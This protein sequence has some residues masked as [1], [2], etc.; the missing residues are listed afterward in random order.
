MDPAESVEVGE[1]GGRLVVDCGWLEVLWSG[2][3]APGM[4]VGDGDGMGSVGPKSQYFSYREKQFS[5]RSSGSK[6]S[7]SSWAVIQ[8]YLVRSAR[9]L[10]SVEFGL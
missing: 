10:V 7:F 5:D 4:A 3:Q 2:V 6:P 9:R 1:V 8:Q